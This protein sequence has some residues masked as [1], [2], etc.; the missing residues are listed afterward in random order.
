MG[1]LKVKMMFSQPE[2]LQI[3]KKLLSTE[4]QRKKTI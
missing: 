1:S 2:N 4:A 3:L